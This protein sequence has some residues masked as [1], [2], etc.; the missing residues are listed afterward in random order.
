M[1]VKLRLVDFVSTIRPHCTNFAVPMTDFSAQCEANLSQPD[2]SAS[3]VSV[4]A[5][6]PGKFLS[7]ARAV[8]HSKTLRSFKHLAFL[9]NWFNIHFSTALPA[10]RAYLFVS[11]ED[12]AWFTLYACDVS[13]SKDKK[14]Q[15][16]ESG[17]LYF[18]MAA[19]LQVKE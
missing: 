9:F 7:P 19:S 13:T 1:L 4:K 3:Q 8:S 17:M 18:Q 5:L 2:S 16:K 6:A 15:D 10:C 11:F 14:K 12:S